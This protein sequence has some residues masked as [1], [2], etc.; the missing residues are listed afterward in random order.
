MPTRWRG[1]RCST[2]RACSRSSFAG[3]RRG[4]VGSPGAGHGPVDPRDRGAQD[5]DQGSGSPVDADEPVDRQDHPGRSGRAGAMG[6][7]EPA[8]QSGCEA[9]RGVD[10]ES[11]ERTTPGSN[12]RT[13]GSRQRRRRS[14]ST[15]ATRAVAFTDLAAEIATEVRL[16]ARHRNE[17]AI[18]ATERET[19]YNSVDPAGSR[20]ASP[21][22]P[23]SAVQRSSRRW[24]T[25]TRFPTGKQFRCFTGL[26]PKASET[27][28]TDR[29][30]QS[31]SKAGS[32]LL[33]TTLVRAADTARKQDPQLARIYYVQMVERGKNHLGALCVVATHLAERAWAVM[34]RRPPT[35][36][37]T[38]TA[39]KSPP[40]KRPRSSPSM[41][42]P[43][44]RPSPPTQQQDQGE[45]PPSR[46]TASTS[47]GR[48]SPI[49]IVTPTTRRRQHPTQRETT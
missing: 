4:C 10:H 45:G 7:P 19:A 20:A 24:A 37:A 23:T 22:S 14:S 6:G 30:G 43:R 1:S 13:S 25:R 36:S 46:R 21:A 47:T 12:V 35:S 17:L 32:S 9:A 42:R 5:A 33:R 49:G 11:I 2:R 18:H 15:A 39:P 26:A 40:T 41:D 28:D 44:R 38:S 29:K 16:R 27:G 34:N 31:M 8:G 48:P 3:W